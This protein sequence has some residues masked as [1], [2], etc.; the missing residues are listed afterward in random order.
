MF[1][2]MTFCHSAGGISSNGRLVRLE[3]IDALL[4]NTST[5][6]N[7]ADMAA[8]IASTDSFFGDVDRQWQRF[9][10]SCRDFGRHRLQRSEG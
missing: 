4:I 5:R 2:S 9:A 8:T 10:A 6:P 7:S 1:T 3:K